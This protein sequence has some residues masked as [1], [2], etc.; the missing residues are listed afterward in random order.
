M[1]NIKSAIKRVKTTETKSKNNAMHKSALKTSIKKFDE[2][3]KDKSNDL[4]ASY[5][6]VTKDI[7]KAAAKGILHKNTVAR[8]KSSISKKY[9]AVGTKV[10]NVEIKAAPKTVKKAAAT[11]T[12]ASKAVKKAV[13]TKATAKSATKSTT[14]KS[15]AKK[16]TKA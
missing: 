3:L 10:E 8:K 14:A 2:A 11:K 5:A 6:K 7:D 16:T 1:P 13:T 9:N 12:T 4:A 15:T